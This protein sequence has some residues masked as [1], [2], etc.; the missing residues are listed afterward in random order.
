MSQFE[1]L[2]MKSVRRVDLDRLAEGR[3]SLVQLTVLYRVNSGPHQRCHAVSDGHRGSRRHGRRHRRGRDRSRRP[4]AGRGPRWALGKEH[5]R[6][7]ENSHAY[8]NNQGSHD[9]PLRPRLGT[10]NQ[11]R[12]TTQAWA[13]RPLVVHA[14]QDVGQPAHCPAPSAMVGL[15][16]P[17]T[18]RDRAMAVRG[19]TI[20]SSC[21]PPTARWKWRTASWNRLS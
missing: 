19:P 5:D 13:A 1:N 9:T 21:S 3:R 4:S 7:S 10:L 14:H 11:A 16:R 20:P 8:D 2:K 18:T 6:G 12:D 17:P 15:N